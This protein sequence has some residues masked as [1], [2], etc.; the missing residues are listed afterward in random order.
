MRIYIRFIKFNLKREC[1]KNAIKLSGSIK[2]LIFLN[3]NF[4]RIFKIHE[5]I[6]LF[7]AAHILVESTLYFPGFLGATAGP[8]SISTHFIGL[9]LTCLNTP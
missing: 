7:G 8:T 1:F 6:W 9:L 2:G 4:S 3:N 5:V